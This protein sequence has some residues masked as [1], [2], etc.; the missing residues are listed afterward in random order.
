[1]HQQHIHR[2]RQDFQPIL[3][4]LV[5]PGFQVVLACPMLQGFQILQ[6]LQTILVFQI[7]LDFQV[8]QD[9]HIHLHHSQALTRTS[10][11]LAPTSIKL[12]RTSSLVDRTNTRVVRISIS[13]LHRISSIVIRINSKIMDS[14]LGHHSRT[15]IRTLVEVVPTVVVQANKPKEICIHH[16]AQTR[17]NLQTHCIIK[18]THHRLRHI[19]H[20]QIHLLIMVPGTHKLVLTLPVLVETHSRLHFRPT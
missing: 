14:R 7:R 10:I 11:R 15:P 6:E 18:E 13:L 8:R 3:V 5:P 9:S 20:R 19:N 2:K 17:T 1:M 16:Q 4:D 12:V